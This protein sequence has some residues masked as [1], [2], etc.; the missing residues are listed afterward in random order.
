VWAGTSKNF[1]NSTI[2]PTDHR[3]FSMD[4]EKQLIISLMVAEKR[5]DVNNTNHP[6]IGG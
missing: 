1:Q 2:E 3:A 6:E 4:L 5:Q